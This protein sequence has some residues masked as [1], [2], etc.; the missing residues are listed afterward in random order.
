MLN[1][2]VCIERNIG[3]GFVVSEVWKYYVRYE[4]EY[5]SYYAGKNIFGQ[6]RNEIFGNELCK[7]YDYSTKLR[8]GCALSQNFTTIRQARKFIEQYGGCEVIL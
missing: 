5:T 3:G 4:V 1:Q 2:A 8:S 7:R 6:N